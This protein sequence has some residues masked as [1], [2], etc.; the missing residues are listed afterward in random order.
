MHSQFLEECSEHSGAEYKKFETESEA[1]QFISSKKR[2]YDAIKTRKR[3][4]NW[5]AN[6]SKTANLNPGL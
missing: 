4:S 2:K 5:I 1:E 6:D 3:A